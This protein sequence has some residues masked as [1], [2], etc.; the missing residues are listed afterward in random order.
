MT[1]STQKTR[2]AFEEWYWKGNDIPDGERQ[3]DGTYDSFNADLAWETWQA[4]HTRLMAELESPETIE[5]VAEA[6][7]LYFSENDSPFDAAKAALAVI[8]NV[9]RG[10]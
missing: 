8:A 4:C 10:K 5:K 7:A 3:D 2:A 9:G 6:I 1:D